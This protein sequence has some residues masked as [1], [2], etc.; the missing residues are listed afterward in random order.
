M[1]SRVLG[2]VDQFHGLAGAQQR[3]FPHGV[4]L[5]SQ[6]D[7]ASVVVRVHL[8]V[9]HKHAR[10]AAHRRDNGVYFCGIASFGK[11]RHAL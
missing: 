1:R 6:G 5:S 2:Q 7:Y 9:Q 10:D 8:A 11:I 4:R 3:R